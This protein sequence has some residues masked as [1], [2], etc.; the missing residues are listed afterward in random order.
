MGGM[1]QISPELQDKLRSCRTLP[2]PPAIALQLIDLCH[3]PPVEVSQLADLISCDPALSARVLKIVNSPLNGLS[4]E[5]TTNSRAIMRLG[6][7][8]IRDARGTIKGC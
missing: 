7:I 5:V 8:S 1:Y 6:A 3:D 4:M 2:T